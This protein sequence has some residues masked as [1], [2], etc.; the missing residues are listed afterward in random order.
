M[1][2]EGVQYPA[3]L[4]G[5]LGAKPKSFRG[6]GA[7]FISDRHRPLVGH[8]VNQVLVDVSGRSWT[9]HRITAVGRWGS[10]D[11]LLSLWWKRQYLVDYEATE[12]PVLSWD[13][14]KATLIQ[15]AAKIQANLPSDNDAGKKPGARVLKD[16]K[17]VP[18]LVAEIDSFAELGQAMIPRTLTSDGWFGT[19]GR[20]NRAEYL[21]VV[22][23][24]MAL[25]GSVWWFGFGGGRG[26]AFAA[27]LILGVLT[28]AA[29]I[30]AVVVRRLHDFGVSGG[31]L[32]LILPLP[33][34]LLT[35]FDLEGKL[36][37]GDR[38]GGATLTVCA[39]LILALAIPPGFRERLRYGPQ[40]NPGPSL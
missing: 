30:L 12:G 17:K 14:V 38:A 37:L 29:L 20:S 13:E 31:I 35:G 27:S 18:E 39:I 10:W 28:P 32:G 1:N 40:P 16:W 6:P 5:R 7:L 4:L 15:S 19:Y 36:R 25:L 22:V 21:A 33:L 23:P 8:S 34:T 24:A 26:L 3:F 2:G 9:L 11:R